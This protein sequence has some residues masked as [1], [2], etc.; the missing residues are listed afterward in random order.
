MIFE[1]KT[2]HPSQR[3]AQQFDAE[4]KQFEDQVPGD[5]E[6]NQ[7]AAQQVVEEP[8]KQAKQTEEPA[9]VINVEDDDDDLFDPNDPVLSQL[10]PQKAAPKQE[11]DEPA[12][13]VQQP[14]SDSEVTRL[15]AQLADIERRQ[16]EERAQWEKERAEL[17]STN[18]P[19][20]SQ[21]TQVQQLQSQID[22]LQAALESSNDINLEHEMDSLIDVEA[23]MQSE[24]IDRAAALELA[25]RTL[26]PMAAKLRKAHTAGVEKA[27]RQADKAIAS[28][29]EELDSKI[30]SIQETQQRTQRRGVNREIRRAHSDFDSI[31]NGQD[32]KEFTLRTPPGSRTTFGDEL[33]AAYEEG[34]SDHVIE[35]IQIFKD[36]RN[37]VKEVADVDMSAGAPQKT[38]GDQPAHNQQL[39]EFSYNDLN[40]WRYQ[41][42]RNE[43][44]QQVYQKRLRAF[45]KAEADGRVS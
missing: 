4:H 12:K 11:Q 1:R 44:S 26:K 31:K 39:P 19:N 10:R 43:I 45:E 21:D 8:A 17:R 14:G 22:A 3:A 42:Q 20:Q 13:Q 9:P 29:R 15:A 36:G 16:A 24:N 35:V 40:D 33:R 32:F 34:D 28:T 6:P 5:D 2:V 25:E 27:T 7:Q 23:L 18:T 41:Y 37:D 30:K 38:V